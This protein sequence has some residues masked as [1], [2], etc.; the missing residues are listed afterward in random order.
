MAKEYQKKK[1]IQNYFA[2]Y[3]IYQ[4]HWTFVYSMATNQEWNWKKR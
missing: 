2:L 3:L 4:K 1:K